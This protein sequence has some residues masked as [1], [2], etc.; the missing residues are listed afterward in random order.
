MVVVSLDPVA[1][2]APAYSF[3]AVDPSGTLIFFV[4]MLLGE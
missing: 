2:F 1:F 3:A 4:M